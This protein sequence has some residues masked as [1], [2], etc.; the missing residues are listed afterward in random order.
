MTEPRIRAPSSEP[1]IV[2]DEGVSLLWLLAVVV[3]ERRLILA[4]TAAGII[5][6]LAAA[7]LRPKT[8]TTTFSF[9]PQSEQDPSRAGLANLAGQFGISL[10][11]LGGS[12]EPPQ[13][14]ADL[15]VTRAVLGPIA[16]DSFPIGPDSARKVPLAAFL[17]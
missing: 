6:G 8:Y 4:F 14:Y 17:D 16:T 9:L 3:R 2:K 11:A 5:L 10:G 7:L 15:L 12:A 1:S 13:L